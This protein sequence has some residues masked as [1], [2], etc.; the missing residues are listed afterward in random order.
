MK[1]AGGPSISSPGALLPIASGSR[2][3]AM[4]IAV[5]RIG[6][7]RSDAPSIAI[8]QGSMLFVEGRL[9]ARS[10]DDGES[11]KMGEHSNLS[12]DNL[13]LKRYDSGNV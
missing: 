9:T 3:R 1:I 6:A 5:I 11:G 8:W 13:V 12:L 10:W 4:T 7:R 2:P